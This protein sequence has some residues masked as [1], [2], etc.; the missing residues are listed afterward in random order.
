MTKR[1]INYNV[2]FPRLRLKFFNLKIVWFLYLGSCIFG[3]GCTPTNQSLPP[4]VM[5][6]QPSDEILAKDISFDL[7]NGEIRYILPEPALVRIR[8]GMPEGGPLLRTLVDW[9]RLEAGRSE[10]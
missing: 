4:A 3:A 9:E 1:Q 2:Q 8:I 6:P 10:E 5:T 7:A